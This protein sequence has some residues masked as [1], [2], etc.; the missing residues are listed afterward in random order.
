MKTRLF[1]TA[2]DVPCPRRLHAARRCVTAWAQAG[3]KSV[4]ECWAQNREGG[5]LFSEMRAPLKADFDK[6]GVFHIGAGRRAIVL[7]R[8]LSPRDA[9][10]FLI[11]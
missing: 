1:I 11:G 9:P 8:A 7:G 10:L 2:Y 5:R 4:L 3:Q 6:L